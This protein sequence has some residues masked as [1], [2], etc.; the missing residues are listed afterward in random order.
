MRIGLFSALRWTGIVCLLLLSIRTT[1]LGQQSN[2]GR[3]SVETVPASRAAAQA[4]PGEAASAQEAVPRLIRFNGALQD[5]AG[6]PI[7]GPVDVTFSLYSEQTGGSPLWFETQTVEADS[8]GHYNVLLGAMTPAGVPM[9]LF[10]GGEARWLGVQVSNLPEQPRVL[11][12]SV[13]YAM[14]AGDAETLGG[15]PASEYQLN[16]QAETSSRAARRNGKTTTRESATSS[17]T[18]SKSQRI[19]S[20]TITATPNYIPVFTNSDGSMNNSVMY[21]NGTNLGIGTTTASYGLDI[22]ANVIGVGTTTP[23][24]GFGGSLRFRDDT[25]T[26]HWLFGMPGSS[27]ATKFRISDLVTNREVFGIEG[28]A[29]AG[30]LY[31]NSA[32]NLGV[33]TNAPI[34]A[35]DVNGNAFGLGTKTPHA[36]WAGTMRFRDDSG[37]PHWLFGMPNST[38]AT[39]FHISDLINNRE[40]FVME[41]GA[42]ADTLYLRASGNVG[43]GT[44][45][46]SYGLDI[47]S[48]VIAVGTT[49]PKPGFGGALRFRDDTGTP[50]WLFGLLGAAGATTFNVSDMINHNQ[51]FIVQAGAPTNSF[52]LTPGGVGVGTAAPTHALDVVGDV[53]FTGAIT[54]NGSGLTNV[55]AS[56]ATSLGGAP[57]ANYARL[58]ATLNTFVGDQTVLGNMTLGTTNTPVSLTLNG[59]VNGWQIVP[60]QSVACTV[61]N[62]PSTCVSSNVLGGY[63]GLGGKNSVVSRGGK[64]IRSTA[65]GANLLYG[66]P[67]PSTDFLVGA[68]ISGGGGAAGTTSYANEV[69]NH[70]GTVGGG[71][72]NVAGDGIGA[73][74]GN[75]CQLVGGGYRNTAT[76][77]AATVSGGAS[78]TAGGAYSTV[79]GGGGPWGQGN[80]AEGTYSTVAGGTNND[81]HGLGATVGGGSTNVAY[82]NYDTVPGGYKNQA[83]GKYS[84]AAGCQANAGNPG[85]FVWSGYDG[86]NCTTVNSSASGQFLALAPGGFILYSGTGLTT[87]VSLAAGSGTW[88]SLSDRHAKRDFEKVDGAD[89]LSKLNEIPMTTW[90]YNSQQPSVRHLG[91]M[92]QDLYAAFHLGED[93]RHI[94]DIDGQGVAL[95]GVQALYRLSLQKDEQIH[96]QQEQIRALTQSVAAKDGRVDMLAKRNEQLAKEIEQLRQAQIEMAVVVS[97]LAGPATTTT[98]TSGRKQSTGHSAAPGSAD[99]LV[100]RTKF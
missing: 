60:Y 9:E 80:N 8:L 85:S 54:G 96:K 100:A 84:F 65:T 44:A 35:L 41:T 27:G 19:T 20:S 47:N 81:A 70:F 32:G 62:S 88:S 75:C 31:V 10:T 25:G 52:V 2:S 76:N 29:P 4:Q 55:T 50:R 14:K 18:A 30:S 3:A 73:T 77:N 68:T 91:P 16:P 59:T 46:P 89:L 90:N 95:A 93:D 78:N 12:V 28:G 26:P 48:N 11:L 24:P 87:G 99:K 49:T 92:A 38:G 53:H 1:L 86:S 33:G 66:G 71:A 63:T 98:A 40:I 39:T 6:K 57:A 74:S 34:Y 45:T 37:T 5:L 36:G 61:F 13:P 51:P 82:D 58:D 69:S 23:K 56:N 43:I 22:N 42:P 94:D 72:W 7:T 17:S 97:R 21:Q 15:R 83:T 67:D 64:I 79:G